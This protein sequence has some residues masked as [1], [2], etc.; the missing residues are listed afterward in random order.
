LILSEGKAGDLIPLPGLYDFRFVPA[1]PAEEVR[2]LMEKGVVGKDRTFIVPRFSSIEAKV[3]IKL[4]KG[5]GTPI[6]SEELTEILLETSASEIKNPD[7]LLAVV[8]HALRKKLV[9][10]KS[11]FKITTFRNLGYALV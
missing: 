1:W 4:A 3:L 11:Q 10:Y 6:C 2:G 9:A 7:G 5:A 8:I